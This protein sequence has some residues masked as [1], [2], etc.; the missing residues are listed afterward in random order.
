MVVNYTIRSFVNDPTPLGGGKGI[1]LGAWTAADARKEV[2]RYFAQF[3][4][5][6]KFSLDRI[7]A[8]RQAEKRHYYLATER[9]KVPIG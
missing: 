3:G 6:V 8:V 9:V 2:R 4:Y 7:Y 1:R 5:K